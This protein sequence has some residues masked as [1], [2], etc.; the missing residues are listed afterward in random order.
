MKYLKN[1]AYYI[2]ERCPQVDNEALDLLEGLLT[3]NP[4]QRLSAKAALAHSWFRTYPIPCQP[5]QIQK[6][7]KEY[8]DYMHREAHKEKI[9]RDRQERIEYEKREQERNRSRWG[10]GDKK[11]EKKD[12]G[13]RLASLLGGVVGNGNANGSTST[14]KDITIHKS[15]RDLTD[16]EAKSRDRS[17]L[18]SK[19]D[20][21]VVIENIAEHQL[22]KRKPDKTTPDK[23][24]TNQQQP[25]EK[26]PVAEPI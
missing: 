20:G 10:E 16:R 18:E 11:S 23:E 7:D 14:K 17:R 5:F 2:R 25:S 8:H 22:S 4:K 1:L 15:S 19:D 21:S 9:R 12:G 3:Y 26:A 13:S 24:D 6:M